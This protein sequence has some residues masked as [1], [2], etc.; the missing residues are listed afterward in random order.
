MTEFVVLKERVKSNLSSSFRQISEVWKKHLKPWI[1]NTKE[2][3]DQYV[4][5][6][7]CWGSWVLVCIGRALITLE[8]IC[9]YSSSMNKRKYASANS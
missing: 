1:T 9:F 2:Q 3:K 7:A 8:H 4:A 5:E 6:Y